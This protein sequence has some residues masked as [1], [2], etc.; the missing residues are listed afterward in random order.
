MDK[1]KAR[2]AEPS[3]WAG[4]AAM[5]ETIKL[6]APQYAA[7]IVGLQA[8]AGGVAVVAKERGGL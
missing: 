3:T 5:L 7:L 6:I 1:I 2:M 8:I 4:L